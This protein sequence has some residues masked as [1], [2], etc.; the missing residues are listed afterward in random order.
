MSSKTIAT[1]SFFISVNAHTHQINRIDESSPA[2]L[3]DVIPLPGVDILMYPQITFPQERF[4][5]DV[6]GISLQICVFLINMFLV[7]LVICH[8]HWAK[9]TSLRVRHN[10]PFHFVRVPEFPMH[11]C[12]FY[13]FKVKRAFLATE[14]KRG[15]HVFVFVEYVVEF[16]LFVARFANA[17]EESEESCSSCSERFVIFA[18]VQPDVSLKTLDFSVPPAT[19]DALEFQFRYVWCDAFCRSGM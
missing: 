16:Y 10:R 7:I 3:T 11:L 14:E 18:V 9:Q 17:S 13:S 4:T 8:H 6:T 15:I 12:V 5:A 19:F 2:I 1:R